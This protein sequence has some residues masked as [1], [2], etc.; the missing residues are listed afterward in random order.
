MSFESG[1]KVRGKPLDKAQKSKYYKEATE[2]KHLKK[3]IRDVRFRD[4]GTLTT[5]EWKAELERNNASNAVV[6]RSC[7]L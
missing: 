7:Q 6:L 3:N 5:E 4:K 1:A 2:T